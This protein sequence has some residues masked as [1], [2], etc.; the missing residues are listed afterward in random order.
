MINLDLTL[1]KSHIL[2]K[3]SKPKCGRKVEIGG[4]CVF[5]VPLELIGDCFHTKNTCVLV[6]LLC[7]AAVPFHKDTAFQK[8][9]GSDSCRQC[10]DPFC[11]VEARTM[12]D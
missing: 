2:R 3:K 10:K 12:S 1:S 11:K 9:H 4:K 8:L 5:F 6:M 7:Q